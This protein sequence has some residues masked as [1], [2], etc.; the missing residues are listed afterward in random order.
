MLDVS[1]IGMLLILVKRQLVSSVVIT[2]M[3]LLYHKS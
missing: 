2:V 3:I 1:L